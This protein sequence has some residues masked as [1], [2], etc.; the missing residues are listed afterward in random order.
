LRTSAKIASKSW[1]LLSIAVRIDL[2]TG[3]Q[4]SLRMVLSD[5]TLK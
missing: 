3:F 2:R 5:L 1:S 4:M